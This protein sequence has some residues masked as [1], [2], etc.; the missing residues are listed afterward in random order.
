MRRLVTFA[1][2]GCAGLWSCYGNASTGA[3]G[4]FAPSSSTT[5]P[6]PTSGVFNF[7]T[8]DVP[9]GVTVRFG[10]NAANTPVT[11][12]A[13]GN[14]T[15]AGVLDL[16]GGPGGNGLTSATSLAS[17]AGAGGPGGFDGGVGANGIASSVGGNGL[18]PGGGNA[19]AG[20]GGGGGFGAAGVNAGAGGGTG[21]AVYGTEALLPMIGGSGGA[22]G[23]AAFGATGAGGGGGGGALV[24]ATAANIHLT[25]AILAR[26]GSGGGGAGPGGGGSGGAVR[27]V[28][29]STSGTNGSID[30][31]GGAPGA[32]PGIASGGAGGVGRARIEAVSQ[33]AAINFNTVPPSAALP[34]SVALP[35]TPTLTV[36]AVGGIT[37]PLAPTG[38]YATPDVVLPATAT[39]PV[40]VAIAAANVPPGTAV[41]VRVVGQTGGATSTTATLA[42]TLASSTA[43]ASVTVPTNR[44]SII[45]V[46]VTFT[47]SAAA[48]SG[49]VLVDGEEAQA[50]RLSAGYGR[51]SELTYITRSGREIVI[52]GR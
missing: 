29:S 40:S 34:T 16:S 28:A 27:L 37:A 33:G 25:G 4:P 15:I 43:T 9:A 44:P 1:I 21:G 13:S 18:G 22:G 35:A 30:V 2:I 47:L 5:L 10:R 7:T 32:I 48:G 51:R 46:S 3:D 41:S 36:V 38:S 17:N 31:R 24:I 11:L 52:A 8:I 14:V 26:G 6:L 50:V 39:N 23:G 19:S 45:S 49:P 12:L 42:G 20:S